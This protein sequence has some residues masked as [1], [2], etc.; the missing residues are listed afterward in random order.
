MI[1]TTALPTAA[2]TI[3]G[4]I[5]ETYRRTR[6]AYGIGTHNIS[7]FRGVYG[8]TAA[9]GYVTLDIPINLQ[10]GVTGMSFTALKLSIR[11]TDGS[12]IFDQNTDVTQYITYTEVFTYQPLIQVRLQNTNFSFS[13]RT[14]VAGEITDAT[15]VLT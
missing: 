12:Y 8:F 15:M 13:P 14:P 7:M 1:G 2:Q 9:N 3:K 5:A 11:N 10:S 4:S 6:L